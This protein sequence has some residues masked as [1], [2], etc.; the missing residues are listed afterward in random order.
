[1][2]SVVLA[3]Y[4]TFV[5][6]T[7]CVYIASYL[8]EELHYPTEIALLITAAVGLVESLAAPFFALL[9]DIYGRVRIMS[10]G[11][12]AIMLLALPL[13]QT[14]HHSTT[15]LLILNLSILAI[16]LAAFD[17]P[18][19]AYV[20]D[21]FSIGKRY[22]ALGVSYNLG[23]AII[24]GGAPLILSYLIAKTHNKA[25]PGSFL[26]GLA[27][28]TIIVLLSYTCYKKPKIIPT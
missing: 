17:G 23:V 27:L 15:P 7:L 20:L 14:L 1:L 13:F 26:T 8:T 4:T 11:T 18:M 10:I 9:S 12:F 22:T 16:C 2:V 5:T 6:Y 19:M 21:E 3:G 24:G 28:T 25:M